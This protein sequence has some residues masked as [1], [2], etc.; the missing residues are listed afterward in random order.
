MKKLIIIGSVVLSIG[1]ILGMIYIITDY[2]KYET[3]DIAQYINCMTDYS[4]DTIIFPKQIANMENVVEYKFKYIHTFIDDSQYVFL[5]VKYGGAE[6][7]IEK[8]RLENI[9]NPYR[10]A[11][12]DEYTY[13]FPALVF[14]YPVGDEV[15]YVLFDEINSRI[16]YV[17]IKNWFDF[18][19][20]KDYRKNPITFGSK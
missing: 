8:N 13:D 3:N 5:T 12:Y 20:E 4:P 18:T 17:Y 6:Y 2:S 1:S 7:Q 14:L 9:N 10:K 11:R 19:E 15:E 16:T